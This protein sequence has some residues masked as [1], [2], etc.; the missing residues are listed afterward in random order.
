MN[1]DEL[2]K[3]VKLR[4]NKAIADRNQAKTSHAFDSYGGSLVAYADV[5]K[6]LG[7]RPDSPLTR[8]IVFPISLYDHPTNPQLKIGNVSGQQ[9]VTGDHYT[10]YQLGFFIPEGAVVPEKLLREMWLWNDE[11][12]K[13][14]LGGKKGNRVKQREMDG[15]KST[16]LFYGSQGESWNPSWQ[17]GQD[18][19]DELGI[20]MPP[21]TAPKILPP[22]QQ[23]ELDVLHEESKAARAEDGG[24]WA[25]YT[26][27]GQ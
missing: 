5:L 9:V 14:R 11:T 19:T 2:I 6:M 12:G 21:E 8:I 13:G 24:V 10:Q 23:A 22:E 4:F 20:E 1:T 15:V 27:P 18:I 26:G 25:E 17:V 3:A 7:T 16:G